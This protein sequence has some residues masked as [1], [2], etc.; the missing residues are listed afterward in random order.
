M[1]V[2]D[3]GPP[4]P[5]RLG[6]GV[7]APVALLRA[8][9]RDTLYVFTTDGRFAAYPVHQLPEGAVWEGRGRSPGDMGLP[10]QIAVAAALALPAPPEPARYLFLA[11]RRGQ[12]KRLAV[13]DLPPIGTGTVLGLAEGDKLV[14]AAWTS[15]KDEI[16]LIT[17]AGQ[18]IRFH[19][20]EVRPMGLAA[21][22]VVGIKL[23]EGDE[24]VALAVARPRSDLLTVAADG[25][26]KRTPLSEHPVQ[27][28]AGKGVIAAQFRRE[29]V[30]A[31]VVQADTLLWF[32][33]A[34]GSLKAVRARAAPRMGRATQGAPVLALRE[35]DRVLRVLVGAG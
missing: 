12:V 14:G 23:A 30:G 19:E 24:V 20:E 32:L 15:G 11:T 17:R 35:K 13:E 22:G 8:S 10:G 7:Q 4:L 2:G 28:R 21:G 16:L 6:K 25:H 29:V 1:P 5:S 18:S 33:T 34:S 31:A 26:A 3:G 9:T 27:G